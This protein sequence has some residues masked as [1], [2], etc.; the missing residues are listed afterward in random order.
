MSPSLKNKYRSFNKGSKKFL[1]GI[2][3]SHD[4]LARPQI[5]RTMQDNSQY[6][7]P[8]SDSIS[9]HRLHMAADQESRE[10]RHMLELL[11]DGGVGY[12][13]DK[14]TMD[15]SGL[16]LKTGIAWAFIPRAGKWTDSIT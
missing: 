3:P 5:D 16:C 6:F 7:E 9:T 8:N 15:G 11:E 10:M 13:P 4:D 1:S 14:K 2:I 12:M